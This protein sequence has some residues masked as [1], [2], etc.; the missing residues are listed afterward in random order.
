MS[1]SEDGKILKGMRGSVVPF[2][3]LLS[4]F[5]ILALFVVKPL[6]SGLAWGAGLSFFTYPLFRCIHLK[7]FRGRYP[8]LA[9]GL[10]TLLIIFL[11][12]LPMFAIGGAIVTEGTKLY[13]FLQGW[14]LDAKGTPLQ[15]ILAL[16][17]LAWLFSRFPQLTELPIWKELLYNSASMLASITTNL[18]KELLGNAL[19][20]VLNLVVIIVTAFFITRDGDQFARFVKDLLP[21]SPSSKDALF[22]RGKRML[23]S[24]FYGIML[25]AAVQGTLGAFGWWFVGLGNPVFF[26]AL[27]FLFAMLP[28]VGTPI[29]WVPAA[30]YLFVQGDVK[31]GVILM[32]WGVLV[33]S[34]IDNVLRPYF[35]SGGSKAHLLLVFT[36]ILG[37]LSTWGFL[38][39]F[40]GPLVM[41]LAV[42]LL[43]VYR[44]F[45]ITPPEENIVELEDELE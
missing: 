14:I 1:D 5:I 22:L 45:L 19:K 25:T 38:G 21:L 29:V 41:S 36:G 18:S 26:G 17:P 33:V 30:I 4:F 43:H 27:M 8:S 20:M 11:L 7:L 40:L 12:V 13:G 9:A 6:A 35:I 3:L 32:A 10:N 34:S 15:S 42:F 37:G 44:L 23:Y 16:P 24:I 28:F 2:A 39:L 31:G